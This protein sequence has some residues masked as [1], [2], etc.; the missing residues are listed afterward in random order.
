MVLG[1]DH[2]LPATSGKY[3]CWASFPKVESLRCLEK[4]VGAQSNAIVSSR[5]FRCVPIPSLFSFSLSIVSSTF[6]RTTSGKLQKA[7]IA[8]FLLAV[9]FDFHFSFVLISFHLQQS[10]ARVLS[11]CTSIEDL[12]LPL[13]SSSTSTRGS[14]VTFSARRLRQRICDLS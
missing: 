8:L 11:R 12:L 4:D 2:V 6:D 3:F 10:S 13:I 1:W 9:S 7:A 14:S 5:N